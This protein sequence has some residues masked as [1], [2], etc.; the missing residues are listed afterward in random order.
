MNINV[1]KLMS[2]LHGEEK[3]LS[4]LKPTLDF[5]NDNFKVSYCSPGETEDLTVVWVMTGGVEGE[6]K[7][8]YPWLKK[9]IL[10]L[11]EDK[12][13]SLPAALEILAYIRQQGERAYILH[14]CFDNIKQDIKRIYFLQ[15][16]AKKIKNAR[17]ASIGGPSDWLIAS[18]VNFDKAHALWGSTFL[19]LP[20]EELL[21]SIDDSEQIQYDGYFTKATSIANVSKKDIQEADKIYHGL[22][23]LVTEKAITAL[24]LKCFDLLGVISNT[25]CLPIARL[26]DEGIIAGCEGDMPALFTMFLT[27]A[28]TGKRSFMANPSKVDKQKN[29]VLLAHCTVPTCIVEEY[30]LKTHFESGIGVSVAGKF[31]KGPVTMVKIGGEALDRFYISEGSIIYNNDDD[32]RCR[33]QI[34]VEIE[35]GLESLLENPLGNHQ[36]VVPGRV[37]NI[38]REFMNFMSIT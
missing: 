21:K 3:V 27:F 13:N 4:S 15:E 33:T 31:T 24:T 37:G 35:Y 20:M 18:R 9:P 12:N 38:F 16:A 25:G 14:G 34:E 28:L 7:K 5:L 17:I 30:S 26:N 22:K 2:P 23:K 29:T 32:Y 36:I 11:T 8:V 6:F 1:L 10:L 19:Y